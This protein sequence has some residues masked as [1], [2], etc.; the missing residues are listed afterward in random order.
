MSLLNLDSKR[1]SAGPFLGD[2]K[3]IILRHAG[4]FISMD[5]AYY[6]L[7]VTVILWR[8]PIRFH[9]FSTQDQK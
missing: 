3:K 8:R 5:L 6:Y 7:L 1:G 2:M 9:F 4:S